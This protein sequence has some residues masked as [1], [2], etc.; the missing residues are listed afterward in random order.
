MSDY[1][2]DCGTKRYGGICSNCQEEHYIMENQYQE[3][4]YPISKDFL[5][6]AQEQKEYL[7]RQ[8]EH[9]EIK[10]GGK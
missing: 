9:N 1:C 10:V 4:P 6:K 8:K 2:P 3:D 5:D 7:K